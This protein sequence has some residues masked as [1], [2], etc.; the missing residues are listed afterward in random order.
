MS[1][2]FNTQN[3]E[4]AG[5]GVALSTTSAYIK[6]SR[7]VTTMI[8]DSLEVMK[9]NFNP[10]NKILTKIEKAQALSYVREAYGI[11][12]FLKIDQEQNP[13]HIILF[14]ILNS[15]ISGSYNFSYIPSS[16]KPFLVIMGWRN[17]Q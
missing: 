11:I 8:D 5:D 15:S 4:V 6:A 16:Y 13:T 17:W 2:N 1:Q 7:D 12:S 10:F 3:E 14:G 9:E